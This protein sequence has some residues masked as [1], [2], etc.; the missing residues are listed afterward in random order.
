VDLVWRFA[1]AFSN[2]VT[3]TKSSGPRME[4]TTEEIVVFKERSVAATGWVL[5]LRI[6]SGG[7]QLLNIDEMTDVE[8]LFRHSSIG[9]Q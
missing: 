5:S 2:P 3:L 1:E 7:Q 6:R 8:M 4:T 9:R